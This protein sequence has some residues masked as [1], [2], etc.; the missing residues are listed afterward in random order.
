[1]A[2]GVEGRY[3]FLDHRVFDLRRAAAGRGASSTACATR[4]PCASWPSG[5]LP[6]AIASRGKQPYRAPE[7]EPFFADGRPGMGR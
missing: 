1:M 2:H 7:V 5:L 6:A 4:S 3:P